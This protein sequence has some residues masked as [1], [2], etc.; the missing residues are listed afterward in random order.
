MKKV[1]VAAVQMSLGWDV[2]D[3][4][5][6]AEKQVRAAAAEGAQIILLSELFER[7]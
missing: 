4:I 5:R 1:K 2:D 6:K 3:N 7:V